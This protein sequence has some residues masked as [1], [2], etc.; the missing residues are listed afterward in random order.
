MHRIER[1]NRKIEQ[2][3]QKKMRKAYLREERLSLKRK[4]REEK[5][6]ARARFKKHRVSFLTSI[7]QFF[8]IKAK[9]IRTDK[10]VS[11]MS[12]EEQNLLKT[13][14]RLKKQQQKRRNR[15][16][17]WRSQWKNVFRK[18]VKEKKISEKER[19]LRKH[20][21]QEIRAQRWK[22]F[23]NFPGR[24]RKGVLNFF[25]KREQ[26]FKYRS[27]EIKKGMADFG[28]FWK[29]K[30]LRVD[31][32]K[33]LVNSTTMYL[34]AFGS[35]YYLSQLVTIFTATIFD[36]PAVLY[37]YRIF[38][39][40]YTY[41]SLYTRPA[42]ILIFGMGP[43]IALL[44]TFAGYRLFLVSRKYRYNVKV[45]FLW[46]I[47][48]GLN[49]FFGAYI[50]G[51]I[52]RTGFV[53]TTEWI[54]LSNVFDVEEII[55]LIV[56]IIVL[57]ASGVFF[58]RLHLT[59]ASS[60]LLIERKSRIYF[61]ISQVFL[62]GL[63]GIAVLIGINFPKNPPELL[64]LYGATFLMILP[65]FTNYS[66]PSNAVINRF[67]KNSRVSIGWIY[68]VLVIVLLVFL[69]SGLFSGVSFG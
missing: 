10:P 61:V 15:I 29:S 66:S 65:V 49:S 25:K 32:L 21:K 47:F 22:N 45:L 9:E 62:P 51:V 40:L 38:W 19:L 17:Y 36:I 55:F 27:H 23:V 64:V 5:Q 63:L 33:V 68:I 54:F 28:G 4:R 34:L 60:A 7:V 44:V 48:H 37:S 3:K 16:R 1:R 12:Q 57:I 67:T 42:L 69:R 31:M 2:R 59:S 56:S 30:E 58:T 24:L 50:A 52:T 6:R 11:G 53:Y 18:P 46:I 39:P 43:L 13:E 14:E 41:S 26:R 35:I 8:G 20:I